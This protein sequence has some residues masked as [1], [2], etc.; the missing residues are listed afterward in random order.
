[1]KRPND[2]ISWQ[3]R[4]NNPSLRPAT[5]DSLSTSLVD[6]GMVCRLMRSVMTYPS[7]QMV[8]VERSKWTGL[9]STLNKRIIGWKWIDLISTFNQSLLRLIKLR[10]L[11]GNQI[12]SIR[13][14]NDCFVTKILTEKVLDMPI[15]YHIDYVWLFRSQSTTIGSEYWLSLLL[16]LSSWFSVY[17]VK[18]S[19]YFW[20][21]AW[22]Y[23]QLKC[24][25]VCV[26][27]IQIQPPLNGCK[28]NQSRVNPV[29]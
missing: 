11:I 6:Q 17:N 14:F 15:T 19:H 20:L 16:L 24:V 13:L 12:Y 28:E 21:F 18:S 4:V 10:F 9:T 2:L 1:M 5:F 26:G 8:S 22:S 25:C 27:F 3:E 23:E 7:H 29:V